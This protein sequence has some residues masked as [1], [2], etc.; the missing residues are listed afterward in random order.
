MASVGAFIGLAAGIW[1][2][3]ILSGLLP[4]A[5]PKS[6]R[7]L[8]VLNV[9]GAGLLFGVAVG[10]ITPEGII[11]IYDSTLPGH[12]GH[13]DDHGHEVSKDIVIK[14]I[15]DIGS[16]VCKS[17]RQQRLG[18]FGQPQDRWTRSHCRLLFDARH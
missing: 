9:L 5:I 13:E 12:G 3:A 4:M 10:V 7:T 1:G 17:R 16:A 14:D 8:M 11:L 15:N 2:G 18:L 6:P